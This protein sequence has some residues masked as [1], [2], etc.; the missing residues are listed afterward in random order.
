MTLLLA[1]SCPIAD[2]NYSCC[3]KQTGNC[4][5]N[6][7][8][9]IYNADTRLWI[10][11]SLLNSKSFSS[12]HDIQFLQSTKVV[13]LSFHENATGKRAE[14]VSKESLTKPTQKI[15][16]PTEFYQHLCDFL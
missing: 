2:P 9:L 6:H 10:H 7:A 13:S 15:F 3:R 14:I 11:M 4:L 8:S 5:E 1:S 12:R 16:S